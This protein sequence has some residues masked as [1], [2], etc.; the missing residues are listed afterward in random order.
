VSRGISLLGLV[1]MFMAARSRTPRLIASS[2]ATARR[3]P[4]PACRGIYRGETLHE[5][6]AHC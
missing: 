5:R 1:A 3:M 6:A 4:C 2:S